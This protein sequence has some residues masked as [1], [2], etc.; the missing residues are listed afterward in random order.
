MGVGKSTTGKL[1]AERLHKKFIDLDKVIENNAGLPIRDIFAQKG[2]LYF[3]KLEHQI[4]S[5]LIN[6]DEEFVLALGGGTP[7]YAYN[8]LMLNRDGILSVYLTASIET[9]YNRLVSESE[10]RPLIANQAPEE[11]KEFIAKNLFDRS[12]YYNQATHRITVDGKNLSTVV[13]EI[14]SLLT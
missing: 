12:F 8:H 9:L 13:S 5:E 10:H 11:M 3:R 6:D 1:L 4:F 14:E 7:C 2:E